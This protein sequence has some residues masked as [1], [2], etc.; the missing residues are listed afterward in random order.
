M[1][2]TI[3]LIKHDRLLKV[4]S[5][6]VPIT[7]VPLTFLRINQVGRR[8]FLAMSCFCLARETFALMWPPAVAVKCMTS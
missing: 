1:V 5:I 7:P 3:M 4:H 2:L 8:Y 6:R